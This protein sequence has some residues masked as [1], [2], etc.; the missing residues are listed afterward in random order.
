MWLR[1]STNYMESHA[2]R[3]HKNKITVVNFILR[4]NEISV[5]VYKCYKHVAILYDIV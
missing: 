2:S 1:V 4:Q 5:A 3:T